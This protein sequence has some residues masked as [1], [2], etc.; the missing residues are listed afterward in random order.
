MDELLSF[1]G[2]EIRIEFGEEIDR[3]SDSEFF[4][5]VSALREVGDNFFTMDPYR[6]AVDDNL[7][8]S[9]RE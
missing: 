5:K 2:I 7:A 1:C 8:G 3:L 9:R 6:T 4:I